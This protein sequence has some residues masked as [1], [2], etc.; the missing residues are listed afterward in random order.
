MSIYKSEYSIE[1]YPSEVL[2]SYF[3]VKY[4]NVHLKDDLEYKFRFYRRPFDINY[5]KQH[6]LMYHIWKHSIMWRY[7][8]ETFTMTLST[9][10][11]MLIIS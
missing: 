9:I 1:G 2:T 5:Y 7:Y 6:S 10:I 8:I 11:F 4:G 3:L